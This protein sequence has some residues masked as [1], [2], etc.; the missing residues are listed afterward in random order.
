MD[1]SFGVSGNLASLAGWPAF[2]RKR[3]HHSDQ[4]PPWGL[5]L[6]SLGPGHGFPTTLVGWSHGS[7]RGGLIAPVQEPRCLAEGT[8]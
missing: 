3:D 4:A 2:P 1:L 7:L 8:P 6:G 5:I